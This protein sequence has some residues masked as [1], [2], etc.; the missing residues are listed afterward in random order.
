MRTLL[1]H[2]RGGFV[3]AAITYRALFNWTH[4]FMYTTTLLLSPLFQLLLFA[5]IGRLTGVESD[6]Y[7]VVG[8][9][10]LACSIAC[11]FGGT[12]AIANER[13]YRTLGPILASPANRGV[14]FLSRGLP[15]IVHGLGA[16]LF[17]LAAGALLLGFRM[18]LARLPLLV[19][20]IVLAS[21]SCSAFGLTLGSLGLR[22]R[23]VFIVSNLAENLLLI[24][25]GANVP[26]ELLP[27]WLQVIGSGLPLTH[28][29]AAARLIADGAS[30][31]KVWMQVVGE[32]CVLAAYVA[33]ALLLMKLFEHASRRR[34]VLDAI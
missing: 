27:S 1:R 6:S 26:R 16:A 30:L 20:V 22:F 3:G 9:S 34:G 4:P 17:I 32:A 25:S 28:A 11:I 21:A 33:A 15:Y 8:N 7:F 14:M 12:M 10:I 29:I 31:D 5:Y 24:V 23:D 18:P 19:A 2:L 13:R